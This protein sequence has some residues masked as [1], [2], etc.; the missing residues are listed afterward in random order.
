[1]ESTCATLVAPG[2]L[3][4]AGFIAELRKIGLR[5][6]AELSEIVENHKRAR[7]AAAALAGLLIGFE[8][9]EDRQGICG[10]H[11]IIIKT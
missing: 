2:Q 8:A 6:A 4:V 7:N 9:R 5:I 1:M 11:V 10:F 3:I